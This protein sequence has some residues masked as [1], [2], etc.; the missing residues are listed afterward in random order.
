MPD[1]IITAWDVVELV[2]NKPQTLFYP[3][4]GAMYGLKFANS[5][6]LRGALFDYFREK[7]GKS[8]SDADLEDFRKTSNENCRNARKRLI[9]EAVEFGLCSPDR[10]GDDGLYEK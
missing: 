4:T 5:E 6:Q 8:I 7:M 1:G 9:A 2:D 10:L 3:I